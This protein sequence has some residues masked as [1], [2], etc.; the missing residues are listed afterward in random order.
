MSDDGV[1]T[2][3]HALTGKPLKQRKLDFGGTR[4]TAFARTLKG[5]NIAFGFADGTVRFGKISFR[6]QVLPAEKT[7]GGLTK[8]NERDV[9]DGKVVFFENSR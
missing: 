7:P 5:G 8:I 3:L 9:T 2:P 4:A 1:L 6:T